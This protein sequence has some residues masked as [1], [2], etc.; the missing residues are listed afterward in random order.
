MC[1]AEGM[2]LDAIGVE[3]KFGRLRTHL[4]SFIRELASQ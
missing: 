1:L 3:V 2:A 4:N